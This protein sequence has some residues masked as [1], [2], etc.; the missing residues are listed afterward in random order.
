MIKK[1]TDYLD[2]VRHISFFVMPLFCCVILKLINGLMGTIHIVH[3]GDQNDSIKP[4]TSISPPG[5][6]ID[7]TLVRLQG[8]VR[9]GQA[10]GSTK[11]CSSIHTHSRTHTYTNVHSLCP[12]LLQISAHGLLAPTAA[13]SSWRFSP[14]VNEEDTT[15][16]RCSWSFA[17]KIH[18]SNMQA[19]NV[20]PFNASAT[21]K[22]TIE[23]I[24]PTALH[25]NVNKSD[26]KIFAMRQASAVIQTETW[27]IQSVLATQSPGYR[28][29]SK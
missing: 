4:R 8:D 7:W 17:K 11:V 12:N 27:Y 1:G 19:Q 25:A 29:S 21:L 10:G 13:A 23:C 2:N 24:L 20:N 9:E 5:W 18:C 26:C 14:S 15:L 16:W 22:T 3:T 6:G 28:S